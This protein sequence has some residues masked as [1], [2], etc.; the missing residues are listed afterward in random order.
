MI[1]FKTVKNGDLSEIEAMSRELT[2]SEREAIIGAAE[3]Y[4]ELSKEGELE[5]AIAISNGC[6]CTRVFDFGRYYFLAPEELSRTAEL[7]LAYRDIFEYARREELYI[8]FHE[9]PRAH[10]FVILSLARHIDAD[11]EGTDGESFFV[12]VKTECEILDEIPE[13][14]NGD[15]VIR[16]LLPSDA[17]LYSALCRDKSVNENFG[18]SPTDEY[19]GAAAEELVELAIDEFDRGVSVPLALE[20]KGEFVGDAVLYAFDGMGCA[21]A[22]M[23]ILPEKQ[24]AGLGSQ[25]LETLFDYSA[26]IGLLRLSACVKKEN[27]PSLSMCRKHMAEI[28]TD[29]DCVLFFKD[30]L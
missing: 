13:V 4:S 8:R 1:S 23:R 14:R 18:Y 7:S 30:L 10:F 22:A 15:F 16:S 24:G 29:G 25:F 12:K 9:V 6:L 20:Y 2:K 19:R 21:E 26:G 3:D 5:F 28:E 17:E 27:A 11:A